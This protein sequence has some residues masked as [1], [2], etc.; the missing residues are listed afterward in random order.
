MSRR[1]TTDAQGIHLYWHI[2]S[3]ILS[4]LGLLEGL[5]TKIAYAIP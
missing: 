5:V 4:M 2:L 3:G 1:P